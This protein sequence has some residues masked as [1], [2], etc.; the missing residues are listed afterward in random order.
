MNSS[1]YQALHQGAALFDAAGR[2]KIRVSGDDRARLLHAM[3]TNHVEGL[4][5]GHCL[6]A[7]F[8]NSQGR[9]LADVNIWNMGESLLL[10]TEPSTAQLVFE[11]LDKFIIADDVALMNETT[12]TASLLV[13]GPNA[14][15]VVEKAGLPV[16]EVNQ[17]AEKNGISIARTKSI[18]ICCSLDEKSALMTKLHEA[19]AVDASSDDLLVFHLEQQIPS[20][21][22]DFSD[23]HI[24]QETNLMHAIHFKKGC[25]LGQEIVERVRSRGLVNRLLTPLSIEGTEVPASYTEILSESKPVGKITS[26]AFSPTA[27][28]V[29]AFGYLRAEIVRNKSL[30]GSPQLM[31]G[32][33]VAQILQNLEGNA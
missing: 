8:L 20:F 15:A 27:G 6:Y 10:D 18:S 21:G 5:P 19:G 32:E 26:A 23:K 2:G 25:Y 3:T 16:P 17:V 29:L 22:I 30:A 12:G 14:A 24:A 7:F 33:A 11:H 13:D 31:V 4:Q 9:I 28:K 1:G